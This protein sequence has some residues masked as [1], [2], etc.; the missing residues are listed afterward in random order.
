MGVVV[1]VRG[2]SSSYVRGHFHMCAFV[3]EQTQV[4]EV[5]GVD[6]LWWWRTMVVV[7][8]S[9][10]MRLGWGHCGRTLIGVMVVMAS[11]D[12]VIVVVVV[13]VMVTMVVVGHVVILVHHCCW[14]AMGVVIVSHVTEGGGQNS[15]V[16]VTTA[17]VVTI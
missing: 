3:F 7:V 16:M 11:V 4:S 8:W 9:S 17:C 10:W 12:G 15:P 5:V 14:W 6:V 2:H 13:V 1:F